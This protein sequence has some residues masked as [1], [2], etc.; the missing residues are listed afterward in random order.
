LPWLV[1]C[2]A[3]LCTSQKECN[4]Y[5]LTAAQCF[6]LAH[7]NDWFR[8]FVISS[9]PPIC[10][11]SFSFIG[12]VAKEYITT[13][14]CEK[15]FCRVTYWAPLELAQK[16]TSFGLKDLEVALARQRQMIWY[17][18][19]FKGRLNCYAPFLICFMCNFWFDSIFNF[20]VKK[21]TLL[22][23]KKGYSNLKI[24]FESQ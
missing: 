11:P 18:T 8:W 3:T 16:S 9:P 5:D 14:G 13:L 22:C 20:F 4:K 10:Y 19:Y 7:H 12:G 23:I 2:S 6:W 1:K 15:Y 24:M 21:Y 17:S